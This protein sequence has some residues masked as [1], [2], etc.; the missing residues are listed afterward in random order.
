MAGE[1]N[2]TAPQSASLQ[3][4]RLR[5]NRVSLAST[6]FFSSFVTL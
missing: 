1:M 3:V 2:N 4:R 6:S 5:E